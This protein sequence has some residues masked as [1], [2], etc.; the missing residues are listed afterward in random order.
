MSE[1]LPLRTDSYGRIVIPEARGKAAAHD[2]WMAQGGG[3]YRHSGQFRH[4]SMKGKTYDQAKQQF[5][6][7]WAGASDAVKE[8]Y[9][10]RSNSDLAPSEVAANRRLIEGIQPTPAG[11]A[12]P[13]MSS[14]GGAKPDMSSAGVQKR[15]MA[16][17]GFEKDKN[18]NAV[19]IGSPVVA[20]RNARADSLNP[21]S[22]NIVAGPPAPKAVAQ[23]SDPVNIGSPE[24]QSRVQ[25]E[26]E[27][28]AGLG[29]ADNAGTVSNTAAALAS[30]PTSVPEASMLPDDS[31]KPLISQRNVPTS[32]NQVTG[33]TGRNGVLTPSVNPSLKIDTTQ[34]PPV[35]AKKLTPTAGNL[36]QVAEGSLDKSS[37]DLSDKQKP[38]APPAASPSTSAAAP[39]VAG[40]KRPTPINSTTGLP[41]G[42]I[43][44]DDTQGMSAGTQD[45]AN[46]SNARQAAATSSDLATPAQYAGAK[47]MMERD[48]NSAR[49]APASLIAGVT[50]PSG[51]DPT[52]APAAPASDPI[53]AADAPTV[54]PDS[55]AQAK[56]SAMSVP[57][58][59][60][61]S[62]QKFFTGRTLPLDQLVA[63]RTSTQIAQG[64]KKPAPKPAISWR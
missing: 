10:G 24:E 25:A 4:G 21:G 32:T 46:E 3:T 1:P 50:R 47:S 2:A 15:R 49:T 13:D 51:P 37:L 59:E 45:K 27:R 44:G 55:A 38:A 11:G 19:K 36:V 35:V 16:S 18:G 54:T 52:S 34:A 8:K 7:M 57:D 40:I 23:A 9:A 56:V 26:L 42:W 64:F 14:A 31:P 33:A 60:K 28:T 5:E 61:A 58:L 48:G 6:A 12:K 41:M 53:V 17:Y 30:K 39:T 62:G 43:P 63:G 20:T 29:T 22:S